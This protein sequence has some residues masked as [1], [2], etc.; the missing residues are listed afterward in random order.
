MYYQ[1]IRTKINILNK[2]EVV[3]IGKPTILNEEFIL[4]VVDLQ[5]SLVF[6]NENGLIAKA[7]NHNEEL[8]IHN[9]LNDVQIDS[10]LN[11]LKNSLGDNKHYNIGD[12]KRVYK[13][14]NELD[15]YVQLKAT[16]YRG[17]SIYK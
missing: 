11:T 1:T 8:T 13:N 12:Y 2:I 17:K 9:K 14:L 5:T 10:L 3:T 6:D 4:F 15:N 7:L 16:D